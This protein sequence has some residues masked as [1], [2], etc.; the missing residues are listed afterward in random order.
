[1]K[2]T[3]CIFIAIII[4]LFSISCSKTETPTETQKGTE[5]QIH[6]ENQKP[7]ETQKTT[8]TQ[9]TEPQIEYKENLEAYFK[10]SNNSINWNPIIDA[11]F[12][13]INVY[14]EENHI[15]CIPGRNKTYIIIPVLRPGKIH[16]A[17]IEAYNSDGIDTMITKEILEF[18][19][20]IEE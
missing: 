2:K 11:D 17:I 9:T 7:T 4:L 3:I 15:A 12:Y 18:Y 8:E 6:T 20:P 5:N 1:M 16:K 13:S 14:Q 10:P 19:V